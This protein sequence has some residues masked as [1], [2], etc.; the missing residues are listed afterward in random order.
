[1][2]TNDEL[3]RAIRD[4]NQQLAIEIIGQLSDEQLIIKNNYGNTTL[5]LAALN[6]HNDV[7]KNS[8]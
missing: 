5:Y 7:V 3:F 8:C 1:M 6:G 4:K 2:A